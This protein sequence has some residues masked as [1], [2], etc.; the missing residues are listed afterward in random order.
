[1]KKLIRNDSISSGFTLVELL[2]VIGIL[3][4]LAAIAL[5]AINPLQRLA[6]TRDVSR[7]TI[8][9]NLGRSLEAYATQRSGKYVDEGTTWIDSLVTSGDMTAVPKPVAYSITGV[10]TCTVRQQPVAGGFCYDGN[11]ATAPTRFIVYARMESNAEE[12]KCT[13]TQGAWFLYSSAEGRAGV[14]CTADAAS[15][16]D[17]PV[18]AGAFT[19][20]D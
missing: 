9:S 19:F 14:V 4:A 15:P 5:V 16:G 17:E 8:V 13:S 2:I 6:Q 7:K 12:S 11:A 3:G 18:D 1:M 20:K 10:S